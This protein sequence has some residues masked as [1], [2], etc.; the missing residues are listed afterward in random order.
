M[1]LSKTEMRVQAGRSKCCIPHTHVRNV[2]TI[3]FPC[4]IFKCQRPKSDTEEMH[5]LFIS[6]LRVLFTNH[7]GYLHLDE[8]GRLI[9]RTCAVFGASGLLSWHADAC[10]W[11]VIVYEA[12]LGLPVSRSPS[13]SPSRSPSRDRYSPGPLH[14]CETCGRREAAPMLFVECW[15]CYDEHN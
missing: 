9:N 7:Y 4:C 3:L 13:L 1:C 10:Q 11:L 2:S 5:A 8:V 12:E 15:E 14:V 6:S